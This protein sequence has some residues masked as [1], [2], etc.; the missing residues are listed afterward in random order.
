M[1]SFFKIQEL[2]T[3]SIM[4]QITKTSLVLLKICNS[5]VDVSKVKQRLWEM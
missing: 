3:F 4:N 2:N 1:T 5:E